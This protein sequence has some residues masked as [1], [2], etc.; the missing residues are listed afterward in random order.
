MCHGTYQGY[1]AFLLKGEQVI[2]VFQQDKTL[3]RNLT[4]KCSGGI[5]VENIL[6]LL[7]G[8]VA[9]AVGVFKET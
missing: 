7:G 3:C 1:F 5:G 9:I 4:G 8:R 2:V 6:L